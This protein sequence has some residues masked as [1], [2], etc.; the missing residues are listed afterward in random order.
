MSEL[1]DDRV[2]DPTNVA[3]YHPSGSGFA[4]CTASITNWMAKRFAQGQT[5]L[6]DAGLK[7][8]S[9]FT[10]DPCLSQA[11]LACRAFHTVPSVA[12]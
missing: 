1:L 9:R 7:S 5:L 6:S 12:F 2:L 4:M 11:K 10:C 3:G 8:T